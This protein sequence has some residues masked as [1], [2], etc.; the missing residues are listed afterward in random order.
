MR[1]TPDIALIGSGSTG[2]GLTDPLD[3]HI[4]A[5]D[6]GDE[7]AIIDAGLGRETERLLENLRADGLD[8][9]RI[10]T[11][12]L[13]HA[14]GDHGGGLARLRDL[15]GARVCVPAEAA[16]WVAAADEE[17]ISLPAARRAGF[18]PID[19]RWRPCPV[20]LAVADG[21]AIPVGR[22][23]LR[24]IETPGHSRGHCSYLLDGAAGRCLL[25]G[26]L[27][28]AGGRISLQNIW[29][30]SIQDLAAS[31]AKL[32]GLGIDAL[33]PGHGLLPLTGGQAHIDRALAIFRKLGVPPNLGS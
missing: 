29:D 19:Y 24:A 22:L 25:A 5:I 14:H 11:I 31:L 21:D 7:I 20:D 15:T 4:Y 1:L 27:I 2:F 10:R 18:Y 8:P 12:L 16:P 6:G 33:L 3:C 17:K 26:D 13:T 30:C 23:T 9:A 32:D 28:F